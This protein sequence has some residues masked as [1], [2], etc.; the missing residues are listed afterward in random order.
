MTSEPARFYTFGPFRLD[1]V[2]RCLSRNGELLPLQPKAYEVLLKLVQNSNRLV[3]RDELMTSV[4]GVDVNVEEGALNYQIR[5]LRSVLGDVPSNPQYIRTIPKLGFRFVATVNH[6]PNDEIGFPRPLESR[7]VVGDAADTERSSRISKTLKSSFGGHI[8]HVVVSCFLYSALF[9][10]MLLMEVAYQFEIYGRTALKIAP[11]ILAWM[12]AT[13]VLA[14]AIDWRRASK[15][16]ANGLVISLLVFLAAAGALFF[17]IG[18]FL[19]E[20][21]ITESGRASYPAE[22]SYLKDIC[23]SLVLIVVFLAPTFHFVAVMQREL[24]AGRYRPVL[25]SLAGGRFSVT[26]SGTMYLRFWML[27]I[28]LMIMTAVSVYLTSNLLDHLSESPYKNLFIDLMYLRLILHFGLGLK[29][30]SWYYRALDEL[31]RECME[32]EKRN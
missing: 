23:Y 14:V 19:P 25:E 3:A 1:T 21:S 24:H 6:P 32:A 7:V 27:A 9:P 2:N 12:F 26:P 28:A 5:Q 15:G 4:W 13:S 22:A 29:C 17:A 31:K 11:I 18:F 8:G 20:S 10:T 16:K 30:L